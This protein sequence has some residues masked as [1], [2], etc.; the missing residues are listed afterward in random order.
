MKFFTHYWLGVMALLMIGAMGC[1]SNSIGSGGGSTQIILSSGP[2]TAPT[3]NLSPTNVT[4]PATLVGQAA[5]QSITLSNTGNAALSLGES[6]LNVSITGD[7]A[8]SFTQTNQCGTSLA[9]GASCPIKVFYNPATPGTSNATIS[10]PDFVLAQPQ[11]I[12]LSGTAVAPVAS[13]SSPASLTFEGT[14]VGSAAAVQIITLTNTGAGIL[15]LSGT[16]MGISITGA[17]ASSFSQ[18]NQCGKSLPVNVSCAITVTFTPAALGTLNA[19]VSIVDNAEGA[20]QTVPLGGVG[21]APIG[22][23]SSGT[24]NVYYVDNSIP[25]INVASATPDC[26]TY[27]PTTFNCGGG[28]ATAFATIA[29]INVISFQPGVQVLFRRGD[30]WREQLTMAFYNPGG[31]SGSADSPI[32]L[33]A[34]GNYSNNLPIISGANLFTVW[35]TEQVSVNGVVSTVYS[36]PYT[37]FNPYS[38]NDVKVPYANSPNQVFEDGGPLTMNKSSYNSLLPGQWFLD[39]STNLIWVRL[40]DDDNPDK[41]TLE[42]SQRDYGIELYGCSNVNISNL[43]T[44]ETS[45]AGISLGGSNNNNV[46]IATVVSKYNFTQG[47]AICNS[48]SDHVLSSI[49][50]NNGYFGIDLYMAPS[51]LIDGNVVHDNGSRIPPWSISGIH[52]GDP[53]SINVVIQNNLIYSNGSGNASIPASGIDLDTTGTGNIVRYNRIY[54]NTLNGI[55]FDADSDDSAYANIIYGNGQM[56]ITAFADW[57]PTMQGMQIYNNTIYGNA[58]SGVNMEGP[59]PGLG[60]PGGCINNLVSNNIIINTTSGPNLAV[61]NGCENSGTFG[62]GNVYIYNALGKASSEFIQWGRNQSGSLQYESDYASWESTSGNCGGVGC[63]HSVE[64][65][66]LFTNVSK[67]DF[68]LSNLSPAIGAGMNLGEEYEEELDPVSKWP[69]NVFVDTQSNSE[70]GWTIGAYVFTGQE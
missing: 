9:A 14:P 52:G 51:A 63:S 35:T 10:I 6:G 49:V 27:N 16:G 45:S 70:G 30:I 13:L 39:T 29:D 56:G 40:Y 46:N 33:G 55:Q 67:N 36:A 2:E 24:E 12:A 3:A 34:Y 1:Q 37:T 50:E 42:A 38:N 54:S 25:D 21:I 66:P 41:H 43:Q 47:I 8:N 4:F 53:H 57:Q 59:T 11:T 5:V 69:S 65:D 58:V 15:D 48:E 31:C 64:S 68:T 20:T 62:S 32:V 19:I 22:S 17:N 28:T 18:T 44:Q 26:T 60:A 23:S 61:V 7:N